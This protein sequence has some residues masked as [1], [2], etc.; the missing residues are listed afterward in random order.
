MS[1]NLYRRMRAWFKVD[2]N[3]CLK[4]GIAILI[5]LLGIVLLII[6]Y[7]VSIDEIKDGIHRNAYGGG[8]RTEAVSLKIDGNVK[9]EMDIQVSEQ[10]Y[11]DYEM[12]EFF[13]EC[14]RQIEKEMLG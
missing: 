6:D 13:Q 11:E 3:R 8:E 4:Y 12:E 5:L 10:K 14:I 1:G 9:K 2:K 7:C